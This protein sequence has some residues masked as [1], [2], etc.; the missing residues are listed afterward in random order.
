MQMKSET[1]ADDPYIRS[2]THL[3]YKDLEVLFPM[4][5]WLRLICPIIEELYLDLKSLVCK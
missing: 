4:K 3:E 1:S 2:I 5:E